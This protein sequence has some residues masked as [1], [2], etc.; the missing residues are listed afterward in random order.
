MNDLQDNFLSELIN[1]QCQAKLKLSL[2]YVLNKSQDR[3]VKTVEKK[4]ELPE[5]YVINEKSTILV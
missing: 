2:F 5:K 1:L 3:I 4:M